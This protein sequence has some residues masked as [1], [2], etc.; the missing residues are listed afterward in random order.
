MTSELA[1]WVKLKWPCGQ[2]EL[3][4]RGSNAASPISFDSIVES[5]RSTGNMVVRYPISSQSRNMRYSC[6]RIPRNLFH[7]III[8]FLPRPLRL[9]I[10]MIS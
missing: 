9:A 4:A 1:T 7:D 8:N 3:I 5:R 2:E 6:R 10:L